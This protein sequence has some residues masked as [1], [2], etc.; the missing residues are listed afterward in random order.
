MRALAA[1][2]R[3]DA[4]AIAPQPREEEFT[5][6]PRPLETQHKNS[7]IHRRKKLCLEA[8][9]CLKIST[10]HFGLNTGFP[11]LKSSVQV[12]NSLNTHIS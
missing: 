12:Q 10:L 11:P 6:G 4:T 9:L 2:Q 7:N 8:K 3:D 5:R 1:E